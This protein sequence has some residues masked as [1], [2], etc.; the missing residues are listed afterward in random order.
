MSGQPPQNSFKLVAGVLVQVGQ[1]AGGGSGGGGGSTLIGDVNGPI[2]ANVLYIGDMRTSPLAAITT[3]DSVAVVTIGA[4]DW[5]VVAYK[6]TGPARY[7]S[8][9]SAAHDGTTPVWLEYGIIQAPF[10]GTYD[11]VYTVDIS[12]GNMRLRV[13]P[14]STGWVFDV[15]QLATLAS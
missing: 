4:I 11:F 14:A 13:T 10:A 2:G 6:S 1:Q 3:L 5:T 15:R 12:A 9:I 7:K 8:I